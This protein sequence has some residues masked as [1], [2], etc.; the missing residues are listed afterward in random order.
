MAENLYD[1]G[2]KQTGRSKHISNLW[3]ISQDQNK[4]FAK[5]IYLDKNTF[6]SE[7]FITKNIEFGN[8]IKESTGESRRPQIY[9]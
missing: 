8:D 7:K 4:T 9:L 2:L 3:H 6:S 1:V 5:N